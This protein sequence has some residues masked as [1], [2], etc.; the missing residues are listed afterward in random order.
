[1]DE[2]QRDKQHKAT[3]LVKESEKPKTP[4]DPT[5]ERQEQPLVEQEVVPGQESFTP[6][7]QPVTEPVK[8]R[9]APAKTAEEWRR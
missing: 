7:K 9:P 2:K 6:P 8:E 4:K 1:M 5:L 3:D